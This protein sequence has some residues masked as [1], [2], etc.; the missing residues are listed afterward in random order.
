MKHQDIRSKIKEINILYTPEAVAR[1][2]DKQVVSVLKKKSKFG[3]FGSASV[4]WSSGVFSLT[5]T[6]S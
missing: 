5:E 2:E 6:N 1:H 4:Y 3:W